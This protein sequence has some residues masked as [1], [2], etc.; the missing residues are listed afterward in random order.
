M[1]LEIDTELKTITLKKGLTVDEL[2]QTIK[3]HK[4][5]GYTIN[6]EVQVISRYPHQPVY[7]S[8]PTRLTS[9]PGVFDVWANS[10][11]AIWPG[12]PQLRSYN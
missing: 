10:T 6:P 11:N 9:S 4:L 3:K 12:I 8:W 5:E 1:K 2:N 7:P